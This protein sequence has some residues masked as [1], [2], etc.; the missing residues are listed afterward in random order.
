[1]PTDL[2]EPN[3]ERVLTVLRR[4]GE[5]DRVPFLELSIDGAIMPL[6]LGEPIPSDP[7]AWRR[8]RIRF[9]R[10]LGYDYVIGFHRVQF[11]GRQA[12]VAADTAERGSGKR[13]WQDAIALLNK[14]FFPQWKCRKVGRQLL[15]EKWQSFHW[16]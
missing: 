10:T 6:V 9:M 14:A 3:F 7:D 2:W 11:P 15:R 16:F 1:M 4:Q 12:L 5:P 8:Y 13:S